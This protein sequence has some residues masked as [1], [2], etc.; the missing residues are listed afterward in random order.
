MREHGI[1]NRIMLIYDTC[2]FKISHKEPFAPELLKEAAGIIKTF[3]EEYH[4]QLEEKHIFPLFTN[5]NQLVDLVQTL[6]IQ[7]SAGKKITD[8]IIQQSNLNT[9]ND[10]EGSQKIVALIE[11]FNNMYRPHEAREDTVLFPALRRLV[12]RNEYFSMGEDFEK[13]EHA[14]F[15]SDG[16]ESIVDKVGNIEKKLGIYDL[17]LFTPAV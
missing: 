2:K 13:K 15:G 6:Y 17:A 14:L 9:L 8:R 12:S 5:A 7:H 3:I 11:N 16:F 4:E 1:L 10:P